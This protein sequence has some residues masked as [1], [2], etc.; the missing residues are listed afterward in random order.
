MKS[1]YV[2]E[3]RELKSRASDCSECSASDSFYNPRFFM[4]PNREEVPNKVILAPAGFEGQLIRRNL[5]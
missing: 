2:H 1:A 5:T 4:R 3:L